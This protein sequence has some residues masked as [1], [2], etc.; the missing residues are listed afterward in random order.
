MSMAKAFLNDVHFDPLISIIVAT[1]AKSSIVWTTALYIVSNR[2]ILKKYTS[3]SQQFSRETSSDFKQYALKTT[4]RPS[5][6][7]MAQP[8]SQDDECAQ[9]LD[10]ATPI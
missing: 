7:P 6:L 10:R 2:K 8:E 9:R 4:R 3:T 5:A 1:L